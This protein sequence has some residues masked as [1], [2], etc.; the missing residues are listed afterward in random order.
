MLLKII[1]SH[2]LVANHLRPNIG[3]HILPL[4]AYRKLRDDRLR[5]DAPA[6]AHAGGYRL[7]EGAGMDDDALLVHRFNSLRWLFAII[8][9]AVRVILDNQ[10]AVLFSKRVNSLSLFK[11]HRHAG[12][13]LEIGNGINKTD[14]FFRL[15]R[16]LKLLDIHA[17]ALDRNPYEPCVIRAERI[18]R[19]NK[20]G[21]LAD[22]GVALV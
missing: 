10:D 15:E 8:E 9:V 12:R 13:V 4:L 19:T 21:R 2:I 22:D 1:F 17:V 7:G 16:F 18:K 20:A 11:A 14:I 3:M 5:G 6:D